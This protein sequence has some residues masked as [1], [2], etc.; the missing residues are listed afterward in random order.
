MQ[1]P[2]VT[3]RKL[4]DTLGEVGRHIADTVARP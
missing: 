3:V 1:Q 4:V 2:A